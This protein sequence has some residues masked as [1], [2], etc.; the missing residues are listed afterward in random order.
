MFSFLRQPYPPPV[1]SL[2]KAALISI[3]IGVFVAFFLITFKPFDTGQS[4][5]PNLNL[6]LAG[7]GLVIALALFIPIGLF[8]RIFPKVYS[9]ERWTVGSHLIFN[10]L[11]VA[12]GITV[13]YFYLLTSGGQ[14]NIK[15]Y[16]YFFRNGLLVASFPIIVLTL[17][18]YIRKLRYYEQGA[19]AAKLPGSASAQSPEIIVVLRDDQDRPELTLNAN[20][21]WCLHS[22]GNYVEVWYRNEAGEYE[23]TVIRNTLA[24]LN[25]QLPGRMFLTCHRS[26]VVNPELVEEITG[27][28]Q[29]YRLHRE[30][31][32]VVAVARGRSAEVLARLEVAV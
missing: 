19:R 4:R 32:P 27:N 20:Q 3:G 18:D 11:V 31:A 17:L 24:R 1:V 9:E 7:Y 14:A 16:L 22:D 13:S 29:G 25:E 21:I 23:R 8:P 5:I 10:L 26:W 12:F 15:D 6:F 30:N 28:A 2:V